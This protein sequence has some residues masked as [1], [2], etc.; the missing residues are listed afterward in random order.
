[1]GKRKYPPLK[2]REVVQIVTTLGF[3]LA[4]QE[5]THAQYE[6]PADATRK[7][8]IVTVDNYDDFEEKMIRNLISQSGFTREE[9]YGATSKT[10]KKI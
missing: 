10:A 1:M 9:F 2:H 3:T 4:R 5:S 8:A 7:R 6:R